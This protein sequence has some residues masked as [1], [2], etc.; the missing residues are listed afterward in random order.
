MVREKDGQR[1]RRRDVARP[2]KNAE[3][4]EE[5]EQLLAEDEEASSDHE[6]V[7]TPQNAPSADP[8]QVQHEIK[9]MKG[10]GNTEEGDAERG[11][12]VLDRDDELERE[13]AEQ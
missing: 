8:P 11:V 3:A 10:A 6:G 12:V 7:E 9:V 2:G 4:D 5:R 1:K 13:L